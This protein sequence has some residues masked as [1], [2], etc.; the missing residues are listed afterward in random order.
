MEDIIERLKLLN[1]ETYFVRDLEQKTVYP[2]TFVAPASNSE[3]QFNHYIALVQWLFSILGRGQQEQEQGQGPKQTHK[4][5]RKGAHEI[6]GGNLNFDFDRFSSDEEDEEE[7]NINK[8]KNVYGDNS[9]SAPF[10]PLFWVEEYEDSNTIAQRLMY[11][12]QSIDF[13]TDIPIVKLKQPHGKIVY[14]ILD[15]L[16][17]KA[18]EVM[19]ATDMT[20]SESGHSQTNSDDCSGE[21]VDHDED[22]TSATSYSVPEAHQTPKPKS[23][24]MTSTD[25]YPNID[26]NEWT[27]E[28]ERVGPLLEKKLRRYHSDDSVST[29]SRYWR[30]HLNQFMKEYENFVYESDA[31]SAAID[32]LHNDATTSLEQIELKEMTIH[33]RFKK[34]AH[35]HGQVTMRIDELKAS[36]QDSVSIL[37]NAKD[38]LQSLSS[39]LA[40]VKAMI[41][42]RGNS[43][44]NTNPLVRIKTALLNI[45]SE[46]RDYDLE[47]GVLEHTLLHKRLENHAMNNSS[48][49]IYA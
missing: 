6:G 7:L 25:Q 35:D 49:R 29:T 8:S 10:T 15:F 20:V 14:S 5:D 1:Y 32:R 4:P 27:R 11:S 39:Q 40:Q 38:E 31:S 13:P 33:D 24:T 34:I 9:S 12:L 47:I 19:K 48:D 21:I 28:L 2:D 23:P 22:G 36:T 37:N 18:M 43:M 44:T 45:K 42:E 41:D 16:T 26:P 30:V 3:L 17:T 46:I